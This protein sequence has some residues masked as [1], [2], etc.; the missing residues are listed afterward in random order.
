MFTVGVIGHSL[1]KPYL[2]GG[3]HYEH[4]HDNFRLNY[5]CC[6]GA[7]FSSI[8]NS[9]ALRKLIE[10][11]PHLVILV[12]GGNDLRYGSDIKLIHQNLTTLVAS[13]TDSCSPYFG[14][15]ILEPELRKGN[16]KYI[17]PSSYV[18]L[19]NSLIRKIKT[20]KQVKFLH[21]IKHGLNLAHL[22]PDGVHLNSCGKSLLQKIIK[23]H[24][25][26]LLFNSDL[27]LT[28]S[29]P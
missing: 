20:K 15:Y 13:I 19:R 22:S 17:D 26:E 23:S 5:Y 8:L 25:S 9:V 14:T 24:I 12:L 21:L 3:S 27:S 2:P 18:S 4:V 10:S 28:K 7:T 6:P 16:P 11:S 29:S 1:L